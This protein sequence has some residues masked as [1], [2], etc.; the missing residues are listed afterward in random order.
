[1]KTLKNHLFIMLGV[2][3][4]TLSC[5]A[6]KNEEDKTLSPYFFVQTNDEND[7]LPLKK[8]SAMVNIAGVIADVT[9]TQEY[10]NTGKNPIEA[11]YVFP[12]ST[13]A[14]V[15]SME[16][17][18][19]ERV[20]LA[21]I[22]EKNKARQDYEQA[23][24]D[25]KNASLLE[26]KRP[27]VFQMSVANIMPGQIVSVKLCYTEL[28]IPE[29]KIYEFIYPSVVGPRYSNKTE[30][31]SMEEN[32]IE[33]P[34]TKSGEKELYEF[35]LNI[36]LAGSMPIDQISSP[37][38]I[39]NV[40]YQNKS[41][42]NIS[43]NA[44]ERSKGNKDFVLRY[45]LS[46][47]QIE[48]GVLLYE[49][50]KENFFLAMIQPPKEIHETHI[51]SREYVFIL[52]VSGSM[53]GFPIEVSKKLMQELFQKLR[54]VDCFNVM[55]FA[56]GSQVLFQNSM[57]VNEANIQKAMQMINQQQ[58]GG[59]T[60]LLP[61][62]K[63]ALAFTGTENYARSFV[64]L[65]D[66]YVAIEQEAFDL[67]RKNLNKANFFSFGIGSSVNRFLIEGI[68]HVGMGKPFVVLKESEAK[69]VSEKFRNYIENPVLTNLTYDIEGFNAYDIEPNALPDLLGERPIILYGKYAGKAA[70]KINI[71]GIT[72]K[73]TLNFSVDIS[74]EKISAKNAAIQYLWA[75]EKIRL[76]DDYNNLF[77]S[78]DHIKE[79]TQL[80]L[81]YNL[82]TNYTSFVAID[83]EIINND[84]KY[85]SIKQPLPLPDGVSNYAIG[86]KS[87]PVSYGQR[88]KK[89]EITE[90]LE[91]VSDQDME[92]LSQPVFN[93]IESQ[94]EFI[95]G[96][97][98]LAKFILQNIQY[99]EEAKANGISGTVFVEF[100]IDVDGAVVEVNILRGVDPLL[101][102][103][104]IRIVKLT[105]KKWKPAQQNGKPVKTKY[106]IPVKF[107]L[108]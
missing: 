51:P 19:G 57:P 71:T 5:S 106:N 87:M 9:I 10:Q 8:T 6:Q 81:K 70:G 32:W 65:T 1:M 27:N 56:G 31:E 46:G 108:D 76:L 62:L 61:A 59:S 107:S 53:S 74:T 45:R 85:T 75:R 29:N 79:V 100:I 18:I 12:A 38:H 42:A 84:G 63:Q 95:G 72:G 36:T 83:S 35:D 16:M 52:D 68:A 43:I 39:V 2:V 78:D 34:Y 3:I 82:L 69:Q 13:K 7:Q 25:G 104:A 20:I 28:L 21:K 60:Q 54:P 30:T 93:I 50:E 58:G 33:N 91:I 26:Q 47:N 67:I 89:G 64:I 4:L 92:D 14:A 44:E 66:G 73:S 88:S 48:A 103:E 77:P 99:P 105:H 98:A 55:F 97:A 22:E 101:N 94:P 102:N 40:E 80:G 37:S 11:I 23:K 24:A 17:I 90:C 15:Y 96:D 41:T 49:G 86:G